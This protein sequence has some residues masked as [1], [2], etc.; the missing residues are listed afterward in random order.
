MS[1]NLPEYLRLVPAHDESASVTS[2][3]MMKNLVMM[4]GSCK[5]RVLHS[6]V[7]TRPQS[8]GSVDSPAREESHTVSFHEFAEQ[9]I[10]LLPRHLVWQDAV[11]I[12][13]G[14]ASKYV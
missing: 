3:A 6:P 2:D 7:L 5:L 10:R 8:H 4:I 13:V 11:G 9:H 12:I 14:Y 1:R